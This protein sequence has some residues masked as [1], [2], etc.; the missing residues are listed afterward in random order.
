MSEE[1]ARAGRRP[2]APTV[3]NQPLAS[4]QGLNFFEVHLQ[5]L[6]LAM[7]VV[8][9][10]PTTRL[11]LSQ[12]KNE[13]TVNF[14]VRMDD[15]STQL[16][17]GYR[18]QHNN[19]LGPYKGGIRYSE[20]VTHAEVKALAA[21]MTYKCALV[22][23]PFG[24]AKGGIRMNPRGYSRTELERI[25]RRFTH[26]LG[27][28]IGP[29][30][31][32]PAPDMGTNAQTMVW[33]MDTYMNGS[34]ATQKNAVRGVVTGKSLTS[35]GSVGREKATGQGVVYAI[36]EWCEEHNFSL[37]GA[38]ITIQGFGNVGSHAALLLSRAGA[39]IVAVQDHTGAIKNE[40]GLDPVALR[41][42]VAANG[43]VAG[44]V[45]STP[46]DRDAFFSQR[47]DILIPAALEFQITRHEAELIQARLIAEGANGPM[48]P[49]G[50]EILR[51]RGIDVLPDI[52]ANSGGVIV[53]YFE[54]VQN[55]RSESWT[56]NEVD[57]RLRDHI[58]RAYHVV[59]DL[60]QDLGVSNRTA[61]LAR[62]IQRLDEAYAER[63]I[64]P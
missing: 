59:R 7:E 23:V 21:L 39:R 16:F 27:S 61:A 36:D 24:G 30:Y 28:N 17:T 19:I 58:R 33:M 35:G 62:A 53:S 11:V 9:P 12:P 22:G 25:T 5:Q 55:K 41:S 50:E 48:T 2:R 60:A 64:F 47:T 45:S 20:H 10:G 6:S 54:W 4:E 57:S 56:L 31:D 15:G 3:F 8:N 51:S 49:G 32:I 44:F 40:D 46:I 63:G 13:I 1:P 26:D 14:P 18:I 52:L 42:H 29:D 38:R 34:S 43:G 37:D